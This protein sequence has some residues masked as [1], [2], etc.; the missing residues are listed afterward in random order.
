MRNGCA[1]AVCLLSLS[2]T[3]EAEKVPIPPLPVDGS[4][5]SYN[6]VLARLAAQTNTARDEHFLNQWDKLADTARA[7]EVSASY[8][9]KSTNIPPRRQPTIAQDTAALMQ[10]IRLLPSTAKIHDQAQAL[11]AIR[12]IHNQIRELGT[13]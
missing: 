11:E 10:N 12:R 2:C 8:L 3:S 6:D 4:S 5:L 7:L 9:P 13:E 1:I